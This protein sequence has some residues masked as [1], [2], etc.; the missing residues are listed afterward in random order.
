MKICLIDAD[1]VIPNLALMRLS[2]YYKNRGDIVNLFC[3][4]LSYYP[5]KKKRIFF[6]PPG[7]D[8]YFC[9]CIFSRTKDFIVGK[10][11]QF[12]GTGHDL[13]TK[14]PDEVESLAPDYDIYP[15]NDISYGFISR[16][17]IRNCKFCVVPQKEGGIRQ[18]STIANIVRHKKVKFLDNNFLAL[19]NHKKLLEELVSKRIRCQFNQG[20]DIRLIDKENSRLLSKMNYLGEYIFAFDSYSYLSLIEEKMPLLSWRKPYQLKFFVYCHPDMKFTDIVR[21]IEWLK[22]NKCLPYVMRD[23]KCWESCN[24]LF[25]TD[26]TSYCNQVNLFKKMT[27][28]EFLRKRH[29]TKIERINNSGM[30]YYEKFKAIK[31]RRSLF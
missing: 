21:R 16:G 5:D 22:K 24:K 12:G 23:L 2:A 31:T 30:L 18:V 26:L 20:F 4:N 19:P 17:C 7:Y 28:I 29:S 25:Y 8:Q 15:D 1:S 27:F 6:I 10:N 11:I 13:Q 3:A 9:S 14:L